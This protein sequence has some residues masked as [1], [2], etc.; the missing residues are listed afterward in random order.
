MK[1]DLKKN[2]LYV[3]PV[4]DLHIGSATCN[5]DFID[6][7]RTIFKQ[8]SKNKVIYLLGDLIDFPSQKI[9]AFD[10]DRSADQ[11]I[12]DVLELFRPFKK[13]IRYSTLGNHEKRAKKFFN[14]D[15]GRLIAN[16]LD[17][18]YHSADFFDTLCIGDEPFIV[19]GK[20]G[21]KVNNR[22]DLAEGAM[23][24]DTQN[25][26]ADLLMQGHNHYCKGFSRPILTKKGLKR[27]YYGFSGHF[28]GYENSYA[29]ERNLPYNPEAFLRF[30]INKNH[31]VRWNEYHLDECMR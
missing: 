4:S 30:Q 7:W 16:E 13:Y 5:W 19:Y 29:H 21:T 20:H 31:L 3:F 28:L 26:E 8:T 11:Q 15:I 14:L 22:I 25:I 10:A 27:K 24:R 1:Y 6:Y 2:K 23:V 17:C 9:G 12:H 18:P